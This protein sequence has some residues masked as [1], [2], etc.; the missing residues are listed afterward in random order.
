[1][2]ESSPSGMKVVLKHSPNGV[3]IFLRIDTLLTLSAK[4]MPWN[5]SLFEI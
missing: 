2:K 4:E 5:F 3:K 1:M